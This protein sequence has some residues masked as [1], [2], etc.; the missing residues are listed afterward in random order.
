MYPYSYLHFISDI[1]VIWIHW[2]AA[3]EEFNQAFNSF[4]PII[5]Q[6][7]EDQYTQR[8]HFW[9]LQ[10]KYGMVTQAPPYTRNLLKSCFQVPIMILNTSHDPMST[11]KP[12]DTVQTLLEIHY[13]GQQ[14]A[15]LLCSLAFLL[16]CQG[17][18]VI[19]VFARVKHAVRTLA[20]SRLLF[21][22]WL[23]IIWEWIHHTHRILDSVGRSAFE[24]CLQLANVLSVGDWDHVDD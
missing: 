2:M 10:Y 14:R 4:H 12:K 15:N 17:A 11:A 9:K 18:A 22:T 3:L 1:F 20:V 24:W 5:N 13:L 7:P 6:S 23:A 8:I 19:S 21:H 16:R